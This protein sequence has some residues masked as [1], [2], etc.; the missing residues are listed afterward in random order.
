[1]CK[2]AGVA[3]AGLQDHREVR[4]SLHGSAAHRR[5]RL[6]RRTRDGD[7][8]VAEMC[9]RAGWDPKYHGT[10]GIPWEAGGTT[11]QG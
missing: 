1:M 10:R 6:E 4:Q 2:P 11:L 9:Q 5:R 7:S 8:P 3:S